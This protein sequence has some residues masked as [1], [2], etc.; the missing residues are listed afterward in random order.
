MDRRTA[1]GVVG[2]L[3]RYAQFQAAEAMRVAAANPADGGASAGMGLGMGMAMAQQMANAMSG[4]QNTQ[5]QQGP[6]KRQRHRPFPQPRAITSP[7]AGQA[8]GPFDV[9]TLTAMVGAR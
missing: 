7:I 9:S 8:A 3:S 2:D 6:R 5:Q 4:P 1:M